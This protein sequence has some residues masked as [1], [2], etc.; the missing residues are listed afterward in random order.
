MPFELACV[1]FHDELLF[2]GHGDLGAL[3]ATHQ[4]G[5]QGVKLD[6]QVSRND[7]Q[8]VAVSAGC[9]NLERRHGLAAA[10]NVDQLALADA[11]RRAVNADAVNEDVAVHNQLAGLGDGAGEAGT[12]HEGVE[13]HFEQFDQVFTGQALGAACFFEGTGHLGFADAVLGAQTLLFAQTYG[14]VGVLLLAGTAM[15]T[16]AVRAALHVLGGLGGQ[17]DAECTREA[18]GTAS[19]S[20]VSHLCPSNICG[21]SVLLASTM[22]SIG[23]PLPFATGHR[24]TLIESEVS[25]DCA[26][27]PCQT[28]N[29]PTMKG[30]K[31]RS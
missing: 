20:V 28:T 5:L 8:D 18:C 21:V 25:M 10:V 13:T 14:V 17:S 7:R 11:E 2:A 4:A 12:Q 31:A 22:E 24:A 16:G 15:L 1:E 26:S 9:C 6:V 19:T 29:Q 3:G 30:P 27:V 23:Q